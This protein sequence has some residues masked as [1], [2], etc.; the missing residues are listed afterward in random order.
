MKMTRAWRRHGSMA[1]KGSSCNLAIEYNYPVIWGR[2]NLPRLFNHWI[3]L[4][5]LRGVSWQDEDYC[6]FCIIDIVLHDWG[7]GMKFLLVPTN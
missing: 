3:C 1:G 5:S 2:W 4:D 7:R 6:Y